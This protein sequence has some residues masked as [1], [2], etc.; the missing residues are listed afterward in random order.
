MQSEGVVRYP[1][2]ADDCGFNCSMQLLDRGS[3]VSGMPIKAGWV[4][5]SISPALLSSGAQAS[6]RKQPRPCYGHWLPWKVPST[7]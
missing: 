4:V 3:G 7:S 2:S 6:F 1:M 5:C